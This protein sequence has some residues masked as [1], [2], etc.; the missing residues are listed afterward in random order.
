MEA[1]VRG[2]GRVGWCAGQ[3]ASIL[4]AQ[5]GEQRRLSS[6]VSACH[7]ASLF[8]GPRARVPVFWWSF[9]TSQI[10]QPQER[11]KADVAG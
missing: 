2:M 9:S 10:R 7:P 1:L 11:G 8:R 3:A 5:H 6:G 4:A